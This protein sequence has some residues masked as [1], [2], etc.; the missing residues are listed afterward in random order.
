MDVPKVVSLL[1]TGVGR[2]PPGVKS[3]HLERNA[4]GL[5][6]RAGDR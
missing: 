6:C 4:D 5:G 2:D 1:P 3:A